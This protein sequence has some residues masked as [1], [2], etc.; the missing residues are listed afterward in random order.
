MTRRPGCR[1][2]ALLII[3]LSSP[4]VAAP[5]LTALDD[6]SLGVG[7]FNNRLSLEGRVDG[8]GE[9]QG[10]QRDFAETLDIGDRREIGLAQL[11][12]RAAERHQL[13]FR[14]Y[15]DSR[16]RSVA[17][18]RQLRFDD[19]VFPVQASLRGSAGFRV[20]ELTY[21]YWWRVEPGNAT[22]VQLGVLRIQGDLSLSG[23][24]RVEGGG[25]AQGGASISERVYAPLI[26]L[27]HRH[28]IADHWRIYAEA[29][30]LQLG[31][32]GVRG[33]A[34]SANAGLEWWPWKHLG[35]ALQYSDSRVRAKQS[36]AGFSGD[37]EV[38][39]SGPQFILRT[40]F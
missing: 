1:S 27:S 13:D 21:T 22:G 34:L 39:F 28:V 40:R 35:F 3:A 19:Q 33:T 11:S 8:S 6:F 16:S 38:G 9:F 2:F 24:V 26:G 37:L 18:D 4:C 20:G 32:N 31:I 36:K 12:V 7:A 14:Y 17:L 30:A 5:D 23:Q 10:S 25:Q 29:R 15:R